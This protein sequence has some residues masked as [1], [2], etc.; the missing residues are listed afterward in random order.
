M[1]DSVCLVLTYSTGEKRYRKFN[2]RRKRSTLHKVVLYSLSETRKHSEEIIELPSFFLPS[3][4]KRK[5]AKNKTAC[6]SEFRT[7]STMSSRN[8][9]FLL[10]TGNL[11]LEALE[12]LTANEDYY[13]FSLKIKIMILG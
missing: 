2:P 3:N 5:D 7:M 6:S 1:H 4:D 10:V 12:K 9:F 13:L 11:F 8:Y